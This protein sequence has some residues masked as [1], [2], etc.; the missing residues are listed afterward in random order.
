MDWLTF[1]LRGV[2]LDEPENSSRPWGKDHD[3]FVLDYGASVVVL[4]EV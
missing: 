1:V 3:G 4:E 2:P